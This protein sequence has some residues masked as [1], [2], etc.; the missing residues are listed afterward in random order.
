MNTKTF[1]LSNTS[2]LTTAQAILDWYLA[3]KNPIV[4]SYDKKFILYN[5]SS[6]ILVFRSAPNIGEYS[7]TSYIQ[8]TKLAINYSGAIATSISSVAYGGSYLS[9]SVN[10]STPYTP[11]HNGSPATK[12]YVDDIVGNIETLLASI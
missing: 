12:K 9:T 4:S 1:Y 7:D 3:G 8:A 10:Y 6:T 2:D 11:V 5:A